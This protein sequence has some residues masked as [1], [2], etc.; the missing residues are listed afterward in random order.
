MDK[1]LL[2]SNINKI[3][4]TDMGIDMVRTASQDQIKKR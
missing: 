3:H 4:T 1:E 2:L